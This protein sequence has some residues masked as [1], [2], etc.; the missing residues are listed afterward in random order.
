MGGA[1]WRGAASPMASSWGAST[2]QVSFVRIRTAQ[3][4][5]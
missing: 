1:H 5:N 2:H 4:I 3:Q